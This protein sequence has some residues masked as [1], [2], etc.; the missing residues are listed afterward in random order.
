[1]S[2]VDATR[3]TKKSALRRHRFVAKLDGA[4]EVI[5]TGDFTAWSKNEVKLTPIGQGEWETVLKLPPGEY[6]YRL[7]VDGEWRDDVQAQKR[8]PNSFGTEN[9][10][11]TI[12]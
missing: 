2:N 11:L 1:M 7:L 5:L 4:N 12:S 10:V 3:P 8:V 9:C 6:Q